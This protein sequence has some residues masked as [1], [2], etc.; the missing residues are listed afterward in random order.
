MA[1]TPLRTPALAIAVGCRGVALPGTIAW[2]T[3]FPSG[4]ESITCNVAGD[5]LY[6]DLV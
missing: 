1:S 5:G 6:P 3:A 2:L 4:S